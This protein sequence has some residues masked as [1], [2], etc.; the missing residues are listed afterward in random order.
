MRPIFVFMHVGPQLYLPRVLAASIRHFVPDARIV[1]CTDGRTPGVE[2]VD[3]VRRI[4]GDPRHLMEFRLRS[5]SGLGLDV[6]ALYLDTDMFLM[7]PVDPAG[8]LG[9]CDAAVCEREFQTDEMS[10]KL[11]FQ[12]H[13]FDELGERTL[14]EA[15][16]FIAC[17]TATQSH[18]FWD[19]CL[20]HLEE[21]EPKYRLWFGDQRAIHAAVESGNFRIRRLAESRYGCLPDFVPKLKERPLIVHCK[22][23]ER[24]KYMASVAEQIG[25]PVDG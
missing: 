20:A 7:G 5:F 6:P 18:R 8:I 9:D 17:T 10:G 15:F 23:P 12:G 24:K 13:R 25:V 3:E 11:N 19:A 16:P 2:G 1:Q 4:D 22:G 14:G 21:L